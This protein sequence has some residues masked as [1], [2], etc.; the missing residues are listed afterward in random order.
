M[1]TGAISAAVILAILTFASPSQGSASTDVRGRPATKQVKGTKHQVAPIPPAYYEVAMIKRVPADLLYSIS[2]AESKLPTNKGRIVPWPWTANF[3]G[4]GYR[5]KTRVALY[6]FCKRLIDQGH[7]SVDIGIAQVNWRWHSGRF[8]GD[9]WAATDPWTNL[10]AAADYLSE[11]YQKSR[12]WWQATGQYHNPT[13]VA[14]AA[15]Y[16]KSVYKQWQYVK[17]TMQ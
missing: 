8:G 2:L 13:D 5:F 16:R 7:R 4:K 17:Q 11:H 10:N 15:A 14:K 3:K 9:L 1:R 6:Q 12:N